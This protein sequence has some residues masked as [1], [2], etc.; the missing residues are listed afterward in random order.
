GAEGGRAVQ[1]RGR[2]YR[3]FT[4]ASVVNVR[5][6]S[7]GIFTRWPFMNTPE[8]APA[9][10]PAPAPIA[11]PLPPPA[12]APMMAPT[13]PTAAA[14]FPLLA[15]CDLLYSVP[16][17]VCTVRVL[18]LDTIE[19]NCTVSSAFPANL[20]D[21]FSSANRT[22]ASAPFGTMVSPLTTIASSRLA[23]NSSP[24]LSFS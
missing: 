18:P 1:R 4:G 21:D 2:L 14:F 5:T 6:V 13:A 9:A 12:M 8:P 16:D 7:D 17:E 10:A 3:N 15:P 23:R 22:R 24:A 11:A 20:P 19:S